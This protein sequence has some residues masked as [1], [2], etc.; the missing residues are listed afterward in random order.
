MN[1]KPER[2]STNPYDKVGQHILDWCAANGV[3]YSFACQFRLE[4]KS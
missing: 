1:I 2:S 3:T 4:R